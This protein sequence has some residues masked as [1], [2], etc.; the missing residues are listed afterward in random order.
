[1]ILEPF[2]LLAYYLGLSS[3]EEY[4]RMRVSD[5]IFFVKRTNEE[6]K[7]AAA[8]QNGQTS[9]GAHDNTPDIRALTGKQRP[10]VPAKHRKFT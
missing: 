9:K 3:W 8:A 10:M 6:I 2:F 4:N 7:R 5:K 1:M